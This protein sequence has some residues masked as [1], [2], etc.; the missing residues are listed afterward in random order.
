[1]SMGMEVGIFLAYALG[2][3]LVYFAGRFLLVPLKWMGRLLIN[4]LAGGVIIFLLNLLGGSLGLF[5]P[6]NFLTA[7]IVGM[8]G[9][10]GVIMLI[11]FFL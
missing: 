7:V 1:M 4:S 10:P 6:L 2:M 5:L 9:V 3:L 8:L 11:I